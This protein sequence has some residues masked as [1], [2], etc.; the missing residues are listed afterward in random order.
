M[1][2]LMKSTTLLSITFCGILASSAAL[3]GAQ[4]T[5]FVNLASLPKWHVQNSQNVSLNDVRQWGVQPSVDLEYGVTKVE[6]RTYGQE[7]QSLQALVEKAPDPSS[8]YGL[9]TF[10]QNESMKPEKGMKLTVVGPKQALLARGTFFVRVMRPSKMS[11]KNFRSALIAIVG[12]A[13]SANALALLPPS[14][15]P[16]GIIPGSQKYI[17]GPVALRRAVPSIPADLVGFQQ[18]AELQAAEY[19]HKG[20]PVTLIFISY[21]TNPIARARYATMKQSL[22]LNRKSG[23]GA[24]YGK[25][26]QSYILLVQG[27]RSKEVA[28]NLMGRLRIEQQISWDQPPPGK[29]VSLQMA[30]LIVGNIVLVLLL[31]GLAV[32]AGVML[33][34]TR[35]V[36]ARWFPHSDWARGYEDS[37]IRL[38][39]K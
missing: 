19:Q 29:P 23:A 24:I 14:L 16:Q 18:G 5:T 15:P 31:V 27:A 2:G 8:A 35:K 39:L 33:F 17:L 6:I 10:Y 34:A 9:L 32:L 12:A 37:I 4:H 3:G 7:N 13:P 20:Q 36:A 21:P 22:G 25:L 26:Q 38:N 28:S 11:D 1:L 30:N